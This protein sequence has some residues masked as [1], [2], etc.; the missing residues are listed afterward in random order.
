MTQWTV[1][2]DHDRCAGSGTCAGIAP[3]RFRMNAESQSDPI[4]EL[5]DPDDDVLEA[6]DNCPA[7]AIMV[8]DTAG[9]TLR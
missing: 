3:K 2:V 1:N 4:E 9:A 6:A 8:R 5:I 7:A